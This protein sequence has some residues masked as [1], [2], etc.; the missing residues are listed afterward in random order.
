[1]VQGLFALVVAAAQT[2]AAMPTDGVDLVDENDAGGMLLGLLEH[3]A[4]AAGADADEHLHEIGAGDGEEGH[5]G[6]AGDGLGE[7]GLAGAGGADHEHAAGDLAAQTLEFAGIAQELDQFM[8]LLLSLFHAGHIGEG[9][10]DLIFVEHARPALT[11]AQSA[12]PAGAALHLAHEVDPDGDDQQEGK[13]GNQDLLQQSRFIGG[14]AANLDAGLEQLVH[15]LAVVGVVGNEGAIVV[16]AAAHGATIDLH[17]VDI[18]R[19]HHF[20]ELAVFDFTRIVGAAG[21]T[22]EHR[23]Q[24]SGDDH[25][26]NQSFCGITQG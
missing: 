9:H 22:V 17:A 19:A 25:P 10:L 5:L 12:P 1:M 23:Q 3:V 14:F 11:E 2:G 20:D 6:L 24:D 15:Q 4:H 7:Q 21:E 13:G 26:E 18:A 16:G 8:H